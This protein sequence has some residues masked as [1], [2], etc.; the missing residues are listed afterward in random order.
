MPVVLGLFAGL[1]MIWAVY[2]VAVIVYRFF[3]VVTGLELLIIAA[4][5]TLFLI[6]S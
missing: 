1:F 5:I 6:F 3:T 2:M 4:S